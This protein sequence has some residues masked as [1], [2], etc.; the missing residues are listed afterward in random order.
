MSKVGESLIGKYEKK[1]SRLSRRT[2][3]EWDYLWASWIE[4]L[5]N[6][7]GLSEAEVWEKFQEVAMERDL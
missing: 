2:G 4:C 1:V 5:T 7:D 6:S 3:Y